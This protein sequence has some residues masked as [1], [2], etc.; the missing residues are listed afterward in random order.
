MITFMDFL[1]RADAMMR[2]GLFS[3]PD[4]KLPPLSES[5]I[6]HCGDDADIM[7]A[8]TELKM[9]L[10]EDLRERVPLPF[11][12]TTMVSVIPDVNGHKGWIMDRCIDMGVHEIKFSSD[13]SVRD[14][15]L[16]DKTKTKRMQEAFRNT[17]RK[18][19]EFAVIRAEDT[20]LPV[21]LWM[22]CFHGPFEDTFSFSTMT[23]GEL[24]F[25][26]D[27]ITPKLVQG[28]LRGD[29]DF[30]KMIATNTGALIRQAALICHPSN[31]YV[32]VEPKLTP[33]EARRVAA[34]LDPHP[35]RKAPHFIVIDHEQLVELN[36][37]HGGGTHA[38]PVPHHRRGH[39]R[40]VADCFYNAKLKGEKLWVRPAYVGETKF[41]DDKAIYNVMMDWKKPKVKE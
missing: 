39:W 27:Q 8:A 6:F 18:G 24:E 40:N 22:V 13:T 14:E 33:R 25:N 19:H 7:R 12:D 38:T 32:K 34:K 15:L 5:H 29:S 30:Q 35:I 11:E 16:G 21:T 20:G 9:E 41:E 4:F 31:Y 1:E 23:E 28:R 26:N 2:R 3:N 37:K 10:L 17:T 36:R